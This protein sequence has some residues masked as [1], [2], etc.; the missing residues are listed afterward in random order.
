MAEWRAIMVVFRTETVECFV[1][2]AVDKVKD[3]EVIPVKIKRCECKLGVS[4]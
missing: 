1:N 4:M 3:K 2:R